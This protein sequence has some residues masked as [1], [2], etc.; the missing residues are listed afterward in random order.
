MKHD[1]HLLCCDFLKASRYSGDSAVFAADLLRGFL[2]LDSIVSS[3][4][5]AAKEK[6][7][8]ILLAIQSKRIGVIFVSDECLGALNVVINMAQNAE[9]NYKDLY[10]IDQFTIHN[11]GYLV[12]ISHEAMDDKGRGC[13]SLTIRH[14]DFD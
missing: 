14:N 2:S 6:L 13:S 4:S 1:L 3:T 5:E 12:T 8:E 11:G 9:T 10:E 7:Q